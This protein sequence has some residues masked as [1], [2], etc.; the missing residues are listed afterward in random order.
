M[1]KVVNI[2]KEKCDVY[3]GRGSKFG[4]PYTHLPLEGTKALF[5]VKTV[6]EAI[7]KYREDFYNRIETD[8][9]FLDDV[10]RLKDKRLGCYCAPK[11]CHVDIIAEF[12][13]KL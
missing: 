3:C 12:L 5:Q 9:E 1:T 11:S 6:E 13:N 8:Q 10:L 7:D 2:K 4:N